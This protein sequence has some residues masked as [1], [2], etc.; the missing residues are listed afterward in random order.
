MGCWSP[1]TLLRPLF[2]VHC[3]QRS[4]LA[5]SLLP[6]AFLLMAFLFLTSS[7][8][9]GDSKLG[10]LVTDQH[11]VHGDLSIGNVLT[12]TTINRVK[13]IDGFK[14]ARSMRGLIKPLVI[15]LQQVV[16]YFFRKDIYAY[17]F[18]NA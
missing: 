5:L 14:Y 15:F 1:L 18:S 13:V 3:S 11:Q 10:R 4:P 2:T 12:A 9:A 6:L 17:W 8:Y 7:S 16:K